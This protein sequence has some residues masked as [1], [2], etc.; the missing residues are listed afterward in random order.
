MLAGVL[1]KQVVWGP[2][3]FGENPKTDQQVPVWILSLEYPVPVQI[4]TEFTASRKVIRI[5]KLQLHVEGGPL[6][7]ISSHLGR[8]TVVTGSLWT[9]VGPAEVTPVTMNVVSVE[10]QGT[11]IPTCDGRR[12]KQPI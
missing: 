3:N 4:N 7:E 1:S 12:P 8:R 6:D 9:A 11:L 5:K 2:P 10:A